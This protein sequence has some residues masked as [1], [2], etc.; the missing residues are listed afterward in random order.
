MPRPNPAPQAKE[1]ELWLAG[2]LK[3]LS[4][5]VELLADRDIKVERVVRI[6]CP[7]CGTLLASKR[8]DAYLSVFRWGLDLAQIPVLPKLVEFLGEVARQRTDPTLFPAWPRWSRI[9]R[10]CSGFT[11][12][13]SLFPVSF[14]WSLAT[15]KATRSAHG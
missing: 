6:A 13:K 8:F 9:A 4:S 12:R 15:L 2:Q 7:A 14:A 1:I 11:T 10:W 3:T 5:L